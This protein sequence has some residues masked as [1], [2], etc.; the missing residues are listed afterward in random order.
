MTNRQLL[1]APE[2]ILTERQKQLRFLLRVE[3]MPVPCPACTKPVNVFDAAGKDIEEYDGSQLGWQ[4]RC[5]GCGAELQQVVPFIPVGGPG[6]HW[7]LNPNWLQKQLEK[8]RAHDA[9][10]A[11]P[12]PEKPNE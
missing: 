9:Q 4:Y 11:K 7:V 10:Q 6:W 2:A 12:S 3:G 5:P 1:S 8:A